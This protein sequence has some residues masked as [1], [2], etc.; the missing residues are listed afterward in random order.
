MQSCQWMVTSRSCRLSSLR[1]SRRAIW[2][3][4]LDRILPF[5]LAVG[6]AGVEVEKHGLAGAIVR[7]LGHGKIELPPARQRQIGRIADRDAFAKTRFKPAEKTVETPIGDNAER[8]ESFS[9]ILC[10]LPKIHVI[11]ERR[12]AECHERFSGGA[13]MAVFGGESFDEWPVIKIVKARRQMA[14]TESFRGNR[15]EKGVRGFGNDAAAGLEEALAGIG[16]ELDDVF[17]VETKG[18]E[19]LG[20]EDVTTIGQARLL[21]TF[22]NERDAIAKAIRFDEFRCRVGDAGHFNCIDVARSCLQ[23]EKRQQARTGAE[24]HNHVV[25]LY[26]AL[27]CFAVS[28]AAKLNPE[29]VNRRRAGFYLICWERRAC[30]WPGRLDNTQQTEVDDLIIGRQQSPQSVETRTSFLAL[31]PLL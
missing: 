28:V 11:T 20:D 3:S 5:R 17:R 14:D 22:A 2:R 7:L 25:G 18:A 26:R 30:L 9:G 23:R 6:D 16:D 10:V 13:Q 12:L 24:V 8:S 1:G 19:R 31:D 21:G 29:E 4:W 15:Q 27:N